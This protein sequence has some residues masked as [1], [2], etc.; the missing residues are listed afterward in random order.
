M[1]TLTEDIEDSDRQQL[2]SAYA[3]V[4]DVLGPPESSQN[5]FSQREIKDALWDAYFD[6]EAV[7][8]ML[9][10]EAEKRNRKK[11]GEWP[12]SVRKRSRAAMMRFASLPLLRDRGAAAILRLSISASRRSKKGSS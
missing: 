6:V 1:P 2:D 12:S 5:P 4:L 3:T 9:T 10:K 8:D 7:L 11:Q